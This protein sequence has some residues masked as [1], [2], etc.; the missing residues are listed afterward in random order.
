[1]RDSLTTAGTKR[2]GG[3]VERKSVIGEESGGSS[4]VRA[5]FLR[6]SPKKRASKGPKSAEKNDFTSIARH[7]V[8]KIG[9]NLTAGEFSLSLMD[10]NNNSVNNSLNSSA[11]LRNTITHDSKRRI[12]EVSK[13]LNSST[14]SRVP[15]KKLRSSKVVPT[16]AKEPYPSKDIEAY[17]FQY[18]QIIQ[19]EITN[20]ENEEK[21]L[22]SLIEK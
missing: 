16:V 18:D 5:Q 1:M 21:L 6:N 17:L 7:S 15:N 2:L 10:S 22:I 9:T 20:L 4:P 8:E 3:S 11:C 13:F 19:E 12:R 14:S